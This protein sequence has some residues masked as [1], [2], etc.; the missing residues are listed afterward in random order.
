MLSFPVIYYKMLFNSE[1]NSFINKVIPSTISHAVTESH[2]LFF[3]NIFKN[4]LLLSSADFLSHF[5]PSSNLSSSQFQHHQMVM[6]N[7]H[8]QEVMSTTVSRLD[9]FLPPNEISDLCSL[10]WGL[11]KEKSEIYFLLYSLLIYIPLCL[12]SPYLIFFS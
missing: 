12:L 8:C 9:S 3:L 5:V 10:L 1:A 2:F 11:Q 4:Q 7:T 6:Q